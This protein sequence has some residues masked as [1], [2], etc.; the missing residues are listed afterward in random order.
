M[1]SNYNLTILTFFIKNSHKNVLK[2]TQEQRENRK[3]NKNLI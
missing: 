1:T 3:I 2:P